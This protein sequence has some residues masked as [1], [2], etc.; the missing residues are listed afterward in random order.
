MRICVYRRLRLTDRSSFCR[1]PQKRVLLSY[2]DF[3]SPP[4]EKRSKIKA[5]LKVSLASLTFRLRTVF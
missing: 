4:N 1:E 5:F 2:F 3:F